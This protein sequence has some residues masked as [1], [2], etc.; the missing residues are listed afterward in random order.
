LR[1]LLALAPALGLALTPAAAA[2]T[3]LPPDAV[4]TVGE[5]VISKATYDSWRKVPRTSMSETMQFL[6]QAEWVR[7]ESRE[8]GIRVSR[9]AV[10]RAF[11]RQR[12]EA[13]E[14]RREYR[15][16]LRRT[17]QTHGQMLFRVEQDLLARR[18]TR[19]VAATAAPVTRQDVRRFIRNHPRALRELTRAQRRR[20]ARRTLTAIHQQRAVTR[21][22]S[23]FRPRW[24]ALTVCAEGYV[25]AECSNGPPLPPA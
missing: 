7:G 6:I 19:R 1:R 15:R 3:P 21:F 4:A 12:D 25:I 17:H 2:Q 13:F 10:R 18:L 24:R 20:K 14:S 16:F 11:R 5:T 8:W 9:E 23:E 22:I